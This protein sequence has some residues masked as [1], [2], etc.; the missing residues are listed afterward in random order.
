MQKEFKIGDNVV[1][2]GKV[3][4]VRENNNTYNQ[5]LVGFS[6]KSHL[7]FSKQ[8]VYIEGDP[9]SLFHAETEFTASDMIE[10]ANWFGEDITEKE[11][12]SFRDVLKQRAEQEYQLYLELKA[13]YE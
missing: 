9:Q 11:L 5:V 8:G 7:H 13:K 6:E 10:F 1:I 2:R 12:Q 4:E 3:E